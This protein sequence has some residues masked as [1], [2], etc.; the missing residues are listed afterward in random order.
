MGGET[1][2]TSVYMYVATAAREEHE[3]KH[4]ILLI[5]YF[6]MAH[7]RNCHCQLLKP[8]LIMHKLKVAKSSLEINVGITYVS[9]FSSQGSYCHYLHGL[10][11]TVKSSAK[12]LPFMSVVYA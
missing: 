8:N 11:F 2:Q 10:S 6:V 5:Y 4:T 12:F 7:S 9:H 3:N 1:S